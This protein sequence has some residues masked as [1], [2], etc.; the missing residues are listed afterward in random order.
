MGV[1]LEEMDAVFGEGMLCSCIYRH[2]ADVSYIEEIEE[3]LD[4]DSERAS[5]VASTLPTN[6]QAI[7]PVPK[8]LNASP[9]RGWVS[10]LMGRTN[11][12]ASYEPIG[13]VEE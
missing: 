11:S 3:Q 9:G 10:R 6:H 12:H 5:L 2:T 13:D 1:P 7:R 8:R 4:N